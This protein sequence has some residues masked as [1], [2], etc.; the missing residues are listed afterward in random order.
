MTMM[1]FAPWLRDINRLVAGENAPAPFMPPADVIV[2]EEGVSVYMDV[3]GL[4][5]DNLEI[6]LESDTLTVRG[7]RPFPYQQDGEQRVWRH[8]ERRFGRFE[9]SLRVPGGLDTDSIEASMA[10]GVLTMAI[11]R[12]QSL[13]PHRVQIRAG[14]DGGDGDGQPTI[15]GSGQE[16]A[17]TERAAEQQSQTEG[18]AASA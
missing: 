17:R 9:R 11:P 13:K 4:R 16:Q 6:E 18:S 2:S 7:E 15:E 1:E 5:T 12:P 3:P 8:V 14:G 10:D